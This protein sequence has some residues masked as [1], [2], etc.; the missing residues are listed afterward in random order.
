MSS[1]LLTGSSKQRKS[2]CPNRPSPPLP[3]HLLPKPRRP[4]PLRLNQR[5]IRLL[6]KPKFQPKQHRMRHKPSQQRA[7]QRCPRPLLNTRKPAFYL[8]RGNADE[9]KHAISRGKASDPD[10][11]QLRFEWFTY[12]EAGA[13]REE[14]K[15]ETQRPKGAKGVCPSKLRVFA[16]LL[17][18][19]RPCALFLL[20]LSFFGCGSLLRGSPSS[21]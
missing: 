6:W 4:K 9:K 21:S 18:N 16:P 2:R 19:S 3:L 20:W 17:F 10:G 12:P 7:R 1:N 14:V 15:T 13:C 8:V 5:R 11:Q